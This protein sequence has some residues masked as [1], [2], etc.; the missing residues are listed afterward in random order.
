MKRK[1]MKFTFLLM[2][3]LIVLSSLHIGVNVKGSVVIANLV[4]KTNGGGVRPDYGLFIAQYLR[5][6]GIDVKIKVEEWVVFLG[7]LFLTHNYDLGVIALVGGGIDVRDVFTEDGSLN[8]FG[9]GNDIP[10]C[11]ESQNMQVE[12]VTITDFEE[13]QQHYYN[14][15]QLMMDK[16]IP[17]LPFYTE[18]AYSV[19]WSNVKGFDIRWG[20]I[21]CLPYMSY[22]GYH[23]GQR[24][25]DEYNMVGGP[26]NDLNPLFNTETQDSFT[27]SLLSE[28]MLKFN[29]DDS[30]IKNG[31]IFDWE[32]IDE[33]HYKFYMRDNVYWAPSYNVT[34]RSASSEPL[35][36]IPTNELMI[37]LRT[38]E[39][40]DGS[41]VKVTA[42]DAVFTFLASSNKL[43]T[44]TTNFHEWISDCYVDPLDP[45]SF[46]IHIDGNPK[47][48][49]KEMHAFFW[50]SLHWGVLPE[51]F[52]NSSNPTISYTDG[53]VKCVGLYPGIID[54]PQWASYSISAFGC[55]KYMLDYHFTNS[56][57]VMERN[58]NWFGV[59]LIDG[60][61]GMTPFVKKINLRAFSDSSS[62]L[63]EFKAGKL[64]YARLAAFPADRKQM[65]ADPRFDVQSIN[66]GNLH[67]M[68]YNLRRP[69]IGGEN[70]FIY[71]EDPDLTNYTKGIAVR[72]AI[73]YAIDRYEINNVLHDG[74]Y[75]VAHSVLYP[76]LT[77]YY[78]NDIIKYDYNLNA[79][80]EWLKAAGYQVA[81][82]PLSKTTTPNIGSVVVMVSLVLIIRV[83]FY[84]KRK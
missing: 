78:Y 3:S 25:L 8:I 21:N 76:S 77:Y 52:L 9:L 36:N 39:Y 35:S 79:S 13:R 14:W 40:S 69:F 54:T 68:F 84:R 33:F 50:D 43:T 49:E 6:L 80:A 63:T 48:P 83:S 66:Y 61:S 73:N 74:E 22:D 19:H 4:F 71:L 45:L 56:I 60:K 32:K 53:G 67:F 27:W 46:H 16:I 17:I 10:Y 59:G 72:K 28:K 62:M 82:F 34:L 57:I 58:P 44:T 65:Q 29:T 30:P 11:N 41:N 42:K 51:F 20:I 7:T 55:G 75:T 23:D 37:G 70:N 26:I 64:D 5:E 24:S 31:L 2:S 12:G 1:G 18:K 47:T 38:G 81:E 15:Q